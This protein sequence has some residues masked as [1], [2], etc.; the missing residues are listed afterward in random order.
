MA[1]TIH[2]EV[3]PT[4]GIAR[5]DLELYRYLSKLPLF[6]TQFSLATVT[7]D[8]STV[9]TMSTARQSASVSGVSTTDYVFVLKPTNTT[10]LSVN[11]LCTVTAADTVD[12]EFIN[13]SMA[14]IDPPEEDYI[15]I[16][17]RV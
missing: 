14:V 6:I 8:P 11:P 10:G 2:P 13:N 15:F 9:N 12:V 5:I 4:P 3:V 7:W 17:L 16:I 1:R